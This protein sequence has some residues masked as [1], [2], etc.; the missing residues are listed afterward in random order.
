MD[1]ASGHSNRSLAVSTEWAIVLPSKG[2]PTV[3]RLQ[4]L[5]LGKICGICPIIPKGGE[6]VLNGHPIYRKI[7]Q[8]GA[9]QE[10]HFFFRQQADTEPGL[11]GVPDRT[12]WRMGNYHQGGSLTTHIPSPPSKCGDQYGAVQEHRPAFVGYAGCSYLVGV[13]HVSNGCTDLT[14]RS[15]AIAAHA[16]PCTEPDCYESNSLSSA[17]S[18]QS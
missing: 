12:R 5:L 8:I 2:L 10:A 15:L 4:T 3:A 6:T 9:A 11:E 17:Y 1:R 13:Q 14:H 16:M 7:T 18:M